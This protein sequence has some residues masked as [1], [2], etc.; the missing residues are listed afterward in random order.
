MIK[1]VIFDLDG[2]IL[3]SLDA[4]WRAFNAGVATFKLEPVVKERLLVL[5]NRGASLAEILGDIYPALGAEA[6]SLTVEGIMVEI[7]KEYLARSEDEV[8]LTSGAQE[9]LS[10]LRLGGLKIGVVTSR[11]VI[12]EKGWRELTKLQVAHFIDVMVTGAKARRKPAPDTIIECLKRLELL[13][14]ECIFVGDSQVDIIAGRAAGVRT[15]AVATGVTRLQA[16]AAELPDF[17]FDDLHGFLD[18][19]DLILSGY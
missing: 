12:P 17:I 9:M 11:T 13:P 3:D 7:R 18:K 14:E 6:A 19:L 8:E 16:L 15:V 4:F 10:R 2:T 1:A 5:M